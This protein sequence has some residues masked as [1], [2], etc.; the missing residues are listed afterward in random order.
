MPWRFASL[1]PP[2]DHGGEAGNPA[3]RL[4]T[5]PLVSRG[6]GGADGGARAR[7]GCARGRPG[8]CGGQCR[9]NHGQRTGL[10]LLG[11]LF[12]ALVRRR[13]ASALPYQPNRGGGGRSPPWTEHA[14]HRLF[15]EPEQER[16]GEQTE[17]E[18]TDHDDRPPPSGEPAGMI[19][20]AQHRL[21]QEDV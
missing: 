14:H 9:G 18:E 16:C 17:Q 4:P 12:R 2:A 11:R 8:G 21:D 10:W 5:S 13:L 7:D 1:P 20:E 3:P 19:G 15:D 6:L